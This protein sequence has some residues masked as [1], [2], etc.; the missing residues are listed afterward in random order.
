MRV[1]R[2]QHTLNEP[3]RQSLELWDSKPCRHANFRA[4]GSWARGSEGFRL[5]LFGLQAPGFSVWLQ[6]CVFDFLCGRMRA[7]VRSFAACYTLHRPG[8]APQTLEKLG[9]EAPTDIYASLPGAHGGAKTQHPPPLDFAGTCQTC[10][11][12]K[13]QPSTLL[14]RFLSANPMSGINLHHAIG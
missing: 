8:K 2:V 14:K 13:K 3:A 9:Y 4:R 6:A 11:C 12:I 1:F 10:E 5:G 7:G